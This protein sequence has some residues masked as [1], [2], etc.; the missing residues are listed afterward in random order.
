[1]LR[2]L[3]ISAV[4]LSFLVIAT[5]SPQAT[6]LQFHFL[7][8]PDN[9]AGIQQY[10]E[11]EPLEIRGDVELAE[12]SSAGSGNQTDPYVISN[13]RI[14]SPDPCIRVYDT[15][16][17]FV[18]RDC[19]LRVRTVAFEAT[20]QLFRLENA[21]IEDCYISGRASGIQITSSRNV[22]VSDCYAMGNGGNGIY[23]HESMWCNIT[24]CYI[25]GNHKGIM[26]WDSTNCTVVDNDIYRNT[27][28]GVEFSSYSHNNSVI[29][30]RFGWNF[31][32]ESGETHGRDNGLNNTWDDG[33]GTGNAY[34]DYDADETYV[35]PGFS[36]T[37]DHF[38]T[39]FSDE[40][41][42]QIEPV[43]DFA[44]DIETSDN[45]LTWNATDSLPYLYVVY[46]NANEWSAG[47]WDDRSIV[48]PLDDVLPGT[49]N[50][51][52][53]LTDGGGSNVSD[54]VFVTAVSFVFGG[55]GTELVMI[56]SGIT[57]LSFV[58]VMVLVRK[59]Y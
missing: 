12:A 47:T 50:F 38:A 27:Y 16:A 13:L 2:R 6:G 56:A 28:V 31:V 8:Q 40:D 21:A 23:L 29:G 44:F 15:S 51:T 43:S 9:D 48:I 36:D 25:Y 59:I 57:V 45:F 39:G 14:E 35:I 41:L 17:Y 54:S 7:P 10:Q 19:D 1:M 24:G 22:T 58:V 52:V 18:I 20:V 55:M 26:F 37:I 49:Y 5:F 53:V 30:N 46:V 33:E 3:G 11:S 34:S 32:R 4:L 42:P